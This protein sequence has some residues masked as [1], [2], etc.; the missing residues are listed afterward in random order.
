MIPL[1]LASSTCREEGHPGRYLSTIFLESFVLE[2]DALHGL[3]EYDSEIPSREQRNLL[4]LILGC[5]RYKSEVK[6]R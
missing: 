2:V 5:C 3:D 6:G 4:T 1:N